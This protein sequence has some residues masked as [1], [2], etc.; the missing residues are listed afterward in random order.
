VVVTG[1]RWE[2]CEDNRFG[3]R[4]FVLQP[5]SYPS[6]RSMGMNDR[7]SSTRAVPAYSRMEDNRYPPVGQGFVAA[8]APA[9]N[10]WRRRREERTYEARVISVR[11]V[12]GTPQQ[13]CWVEK[14]QV[15]QERSGANVPGAVVG[16]VIGGILGHQV[17]NGR[18]NDLATVGGAVAGGAIG[19]NV[20][21]DGQTTST[22]DVRRCE[23]V[24][25]NA[26]PDFWDVTYDFRG[27]EHRVQMKSSP[28]NTVTVNEQGEPRE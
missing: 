18:G 21:R 27:Q 25:N 12:V 20:G 10:N 24:P 5:G 7:I 19:A 15:T 28:G 13:R 26:R 4:C 16:A 8:Q 17:G 22:Q 14:E 1:D 3:G 23:N 11:A 2:V 9:D 6:L